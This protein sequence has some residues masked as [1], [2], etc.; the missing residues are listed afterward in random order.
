MQLY[1]GLKT[2]VFEQKSNFSEYRWKKQDWR[3]TQN[4]QNWKCRV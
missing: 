2:M 3:D 1:L 4:V